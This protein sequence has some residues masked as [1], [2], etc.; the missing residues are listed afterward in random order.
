RDGALGEER[1]K[2]QRLSEENTRLRDAL[3]L[4]EER[5]PKSIVCHVVGRDP[6]RWFQEIVLDKGKDEGLA[7]DA[8]VIV[9]SGG[10]EALVG[11]IVELSAHVSKVMLIQDP[12]SSVAA[13]VIGD[14]PDDGVVEGNNSHE[15][16]LKYL[17]R[18]S[19][20]KVGDAV[21]TSGLGS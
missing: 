5:W 12:L 16:V 11:R 20:V 7:M 15:L 8:P 2:V 10:R 21:V 1:R 6:Q 17:D 3:S 9:A 14:H 19:Q 18:G 13:T 4:R